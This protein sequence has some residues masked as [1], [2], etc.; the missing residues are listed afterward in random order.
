VF[1]GIVGEMGSIEA[2]S[3]TSEGARIRI[4]APETAPECAIGDSVAIDG[5]CLT[6][7]AGGDGALEFDAVAETLRRTTL[8]GLR[9][10]DRVNVEAAMRMGDRLGGHW[11]QGHVDGVGEVTAVEPDGDGVRVTFSAP[12]AVARYTIEKGS[13]CVAGVSLTVAAYDDDGFTVALIPHTR[14]VTTL[15]AL[16]PGA[17]VNLEA[18]L[19]GKY[20]EKLVGAAALV[21]SN[22]RS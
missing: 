18:D 4:S 9:P 5:C 12:G 16:A 7:V 15:G 13:V 21:P 14:A 10:G 6:V 2:I 8:G 17:R 11:V 20:V 3:A 19:V 22:Q 1:T